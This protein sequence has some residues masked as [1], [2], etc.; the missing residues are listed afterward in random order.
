MRYIRGHWIG[1]QFLGDVKWVTIVQ[2]EDSPGCCYRRRNPIPYRHLRTFLQIMNIKG[3]ETENL[4]QPG[5]PLV[6]KWI[7]T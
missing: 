2:V 6:G 7:N 4:K 1:Y 5:C 3:K